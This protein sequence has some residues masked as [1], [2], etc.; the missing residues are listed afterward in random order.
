MMRPQKL[1]G[2]RIIKTAISVFITAMICLYLGLP[3]EFAIIAAIV[4]IEPTAS[5]S[6]RRGL[7][8]LP[9]SAIGAALAVLFVA[10]FGESPLSYTLAAVCTIFL[11]QRLKLHA[12]ILVA[13]LTAV[14]MIPDIHDNYML[15]FLSRL[16][17]TMI[18]L[19]V[20]SIVNFTMLPPKYTPLIENRLEPNILLARTVLSDTVERIV[21]RKYVERPNASRDY[22]KLRQS[23]EKTAALF[24]FQ[25]K[26]WKYHKVKLSEYRY[27][28]K[29][30]QV[31]T[32]MQKITLHLGNL[33]YVNEPG[34]FHEREKELVLNVTRSLCDILQSDKYEIPDEHY[35]YIHDLDQTL[36]YESNQMK[37]SEEYFH[38]F[39]T[40]RILYFQLLSIHDS[41]EEL[42]HIFRGGKSH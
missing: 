15:A 17:T 12:G 10:L 34:N 7:V 1:I 31:N 19:G 26:E 18:G 37:K 3:A 16:G 39:T 6:I 32:I 9:A 11:C 36:K 5:D 27:F 41:L 35:A 4:T 22:L 38:H 24:Q 14:A 40:K 29:L 25:E 28:A 33:Q 20:S 42:E 8:R 2:R 21:E 23:V 13:T 30:K